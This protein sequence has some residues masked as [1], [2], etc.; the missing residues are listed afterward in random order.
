MRDLHEDSTGG[1][2]AGVLHDALLDSA[3]ALQN[4]SPAVRLDRRSTFL[5]V[6]GTCFLLG[7][8]WAKARPSRTEP[9]V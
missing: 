2:A 4:K 6:A 9:L 3:D 7:F 1:T 5:I 8:L